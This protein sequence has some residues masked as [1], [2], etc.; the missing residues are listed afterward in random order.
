MNTIAW[1]TSKMN[2]PTWWQ[3]H[4]REGIVTISIQYK[5]QSRFD[6]HNIQLGC[7]PKTGYYVSI[8]TGL[9][10]VKAILPTL[11]S[12][13]DWGIQQAIALM[14][15]MQQELATAAKQDNFKVSPLLFWLLVLWLSMGAVS[16][17]LFT[18]NLLSK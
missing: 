11:E 7:I 8:S 17:L 6:Y 14:E 15:E 5:N 2:P 1:E 10:Q 13:K 16:W 12:A 3:L 9:A 4:L 18:Q